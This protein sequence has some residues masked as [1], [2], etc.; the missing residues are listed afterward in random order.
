[1]AVFFQM[2]QNI[3]VGGKILKSQYQYV[4]QSSDTDTLYRLAPRD[5]RQDRQAPRSADVTTDLYVTN[6]QVMIEVDREKTAVYGI[7]IDQ[8]RQELLRRLRHPPG[9]DDLHGEQRLP[10]HPRSQAASSAPIRRAWRRSSSRPTARAPRSAR[11][12]AAGTAGSGVTGNGIP[13]GQSIPLSA[14]TKPIN[15]VGPLLVNHQGQQPAVTISFNLAPGFALGDAVE[16]DPEPR[17]RLQPAGDDHRP[18][19]RA[20]PRCSRNRSRARAS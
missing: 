9:R 8:V 18:A 5:A 16:R 12:G 3:N 13:S 10:G 7:T 20:P 19:S 15:Q 11:G 14:V 6:P 1:M 2:I 4:L 17:A